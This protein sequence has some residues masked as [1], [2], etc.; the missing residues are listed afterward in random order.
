MCLYKSV[1]VC[2]CVLAC[3]HTGRLQGNR[4]FTLSAGETL[5]DLSQVVLLNID[6]LYERPTEERLPV[7]VWKP[8]A[9]KKPGNKLWD[10]IMM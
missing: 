4:L 2:V 3:T 9:R 10:V 6:A 8:P 1:C 7:G 5:Y